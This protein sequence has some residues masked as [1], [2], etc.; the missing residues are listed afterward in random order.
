MGKGIDKVRS[1]LETLDEKLTG[2]DVTVETADGAL[3][4]TEQ[5]IEG[6]QKALVKAD[7]A[8]DIL[9]EGMRTSRRVLPKAALGLAL[10]GVGIVAAVAIRRSRAGKAAARVEVL[11]QPTFEDVARTADETGAPIDDEN[12]ERA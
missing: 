5:V 6:A 8:L 10:V 3:L 1:G 9:E 2:L 4:E 12:G 11:E 7:D